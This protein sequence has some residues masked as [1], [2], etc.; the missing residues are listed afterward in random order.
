LNSSKS[1]QKVGNFPALVNFRQQLGIVCVI[2][3]IDQDLPL[4]IQ[5]ASRSATSIPSWLPISVIRI[6]REI[7]RKEA[8]NSKVSGPC[9]H[10]D[11]LLA[12]GPRLRRVVVEV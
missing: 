7:L 9:S 11:R 2:L 10:L 3:E 6:S 5:P 1:L 8:D 4:P 12:M